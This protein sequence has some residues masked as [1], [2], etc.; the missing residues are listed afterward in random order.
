MMYI[1]VVIALDKPV[2]SVSGKL[3]QCVS[4]ITM[5]ASAIHIFSFNVHTGYFAAI[6]QGYT[7][8][9]AIRGG[10]VMGLSLIHI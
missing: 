3:W 9:K 2:G 5:L 6:A 1:A 8:G 4:L 7:A 10:G